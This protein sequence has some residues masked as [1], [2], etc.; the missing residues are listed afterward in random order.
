[1]VSS[2]SQRG[3]PSAFTQRGGQ[4]LWAPGEKIPVLSLDKNVKTGDGTSYAAANQLVH[5][6]AQH[7]ILIETTGQQRHRRFQYDAYIRLFEE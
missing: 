6:L 2:V 4:T 5:K 1:M 7:G 3:T